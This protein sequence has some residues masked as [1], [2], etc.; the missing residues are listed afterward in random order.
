MLVLSRN[1]GQKVTVLDVNTG[2]SFEIMVSEIFIHPTL[3]KAVKLSF[4][5]DKC[6]TIMRNELLNETKE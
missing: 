6:Y 5:A 3:G 4:D 2:K 1:K